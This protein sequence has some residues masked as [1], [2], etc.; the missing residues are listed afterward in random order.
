MQQK[1]ETV[2]ENVRRRRGWNEDPTIAPVSIVDNEQGTAVVFLYNLLGQIV[3]YHQYR[4]H[5]TKEPSNNPKDSR[6][7]TH[8]T[9]FK[10]QVAIGGFETVSGLPYGST[11]YLVEGWFDAAPLWAHGRACLFLCGVPDKHLARF[12]RLLGYRYTLIAIS[13]P[14]SEKDTVD[15]QHTRRIRKAW[16]RVT[17]LVFYPELQGI[18]SDLGDMTDA[19]VQKVLAITDSW[20]YDTPMKSDPSQQYA[21]G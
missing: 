7:Y 16:R 17:P 13:D 18:H 19:E 15:Q 1:Q 9:S 3:G 11:V 21:R 20:R 5:A 14:P 2:E 4:P 8:R 12:L 6:Y 10:D